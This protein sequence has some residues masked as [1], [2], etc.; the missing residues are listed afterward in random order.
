MI[1][2]ITNAGDLPVLERIMQFTARRQTL[3]SSNIA[4]ISTPGYQSVDVSMEDFQEQLGEAIDTRRRQ[5]GSGPL[6][7]AD[8][9]GVELRPDGMVLHPEPTGE[10]LLFHDG[11]DRNLERIMQDLVSNFLTYR[12][13]SELI[14]NRFDIL[15]TAIRE[16]V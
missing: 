14:R 10:N 8:S 6:K 15:E 12:T 13:A 9:A 7:M 16:R 5:G 1:E 11:N 3:I 2:G 4:N